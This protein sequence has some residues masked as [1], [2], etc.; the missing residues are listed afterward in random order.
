M[1]LQDCILFE[2][3]DIIVLNKPAGWVVN[4]SNT[5]NEPTVQDWVE[6]RLNLQ[7][8]KSK[9][10]SNEEGKEHS[11]VSFPYGNSEEIFRERSGIVHRLDKETSGVLL[12]AKNP[13]TL[14]ELL[15][16]FRERETKKT[17]VSLVHGKLIP[18]EGV[19]RLPMGRSSADRKKFAVDIDG[20]MSETAYT[21]LQFF[22]NL[23][24]GISQ[25]KGKSYQGFSLIELRPK[26][27]RTHQIRVHMAAIHHPLVGDLTYAGKKRAV[28]DQEWCPRQ[29]LHAKE[30]C[31]THPTSG[32]HVCFS[33]PL[34]VDL[35]GVL[36]LFIGY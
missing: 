8:S 15:R 22:P 3:N 7:T 5:Y 30:L 31:F 9:I 19:I 24:K 13:T 2:D 27:G 35:Q 17:Y 32:E 20:K 36:N 21:V 1:Q 28:V 11:T 4:R 16:Q 26:T 34:P 29:F 23:P 18:S 25:K 10:Q 12:I 14:V 33:A 6:E